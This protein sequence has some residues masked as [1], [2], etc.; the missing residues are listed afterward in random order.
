MMASR[1]TRS[2]AL[3]TLSSLL[4]AVAL[5]SFFLGRQSPEAAPPEVAM[6]QLQGAAGEQPASQYEREM[7]LF[8]DRG[9]VRCHRHNAV[10]DLGLTLKVGPELTRLGD[11]ASGL[12]ADPNYLRAW[13][14]DPRAIRPNTIMP[15]LNLSDE[16]IDD[17]LVFLLT[18]S[19]N[20]L[21]NN[22]LR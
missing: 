15:D 3:A 16:E 4:I 10:A 14:K 21:N 20:P 13:F 19:P 1:K 2:V 18:D 7:V 12:P 6:G 8:V 5:T 22:G 17:L 11:P 9:C